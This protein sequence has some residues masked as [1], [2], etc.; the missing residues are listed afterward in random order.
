MRKK[1]AITVSWSSRWSIRI[2]AIFVENKLLELYD[3][4]GTLDDKMKLEKYFPVL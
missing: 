1:E 2:D 4:S 3:K